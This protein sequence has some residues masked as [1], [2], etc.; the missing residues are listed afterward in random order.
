MDWEPV[1]QLTALFAGGALTAFI[2]PLLS[3]R[4]EKK[5]RAHAR[6]T[7]LRDRR[8]ESMVRLSEVLRGAVSHFTQATDRFAR[9]ELGLPLPQ[10][11]PGTEVADCHHLLRLIDDDELTKEFWKLRDL[12]VN[13]ARP[14]SVEKLDLW[15]F[16]ELVPAMEKQEK[17]IDARLTELMRATST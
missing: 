11:D 10:W 2:A 6:E 12:L 1:Y 9:V 8:Y 3:Q 4:F 17:A 5:N 14:T 16:L 13:L 15:F 7:E